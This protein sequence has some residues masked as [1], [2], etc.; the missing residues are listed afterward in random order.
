MHASTCELPLAYHS[1][2]FKFA[3]VD[4]YHSV[5]ALHTMTPVIT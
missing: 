4:V 2:Q 3:L 1:I 5:S